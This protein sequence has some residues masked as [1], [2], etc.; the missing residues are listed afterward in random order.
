MRSS[1]LASGKQEI[2]LYRLLIRI[3]FLLLQS[4]GSIEDT[5]KINHQGKINQGNRAS[6]VASTFASLS[7]FSQGEVKFS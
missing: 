2:N 1:T 6:S 5:F 7:Y 4:E 3:S